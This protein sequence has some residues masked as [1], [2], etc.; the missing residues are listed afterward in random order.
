MPDLSRSTAQ[1]E[2]PWPSRGR[3]W[4]AVFVFA[5]VLCVNF[6]DRGILPLLV[7]PIKRDLGLTDTQISLLMGFAAAARRAPGRR[8]TR[9]W[10]TCFLASSCRAPCRC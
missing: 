6:L 4:Y 3:A 9:C 2:Q 8:R 10:P 7:Q 5:V 1:V